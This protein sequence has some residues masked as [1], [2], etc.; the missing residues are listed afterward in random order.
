MI[1]NLL[2]QCVKAYTK[3]RGDL[4]SYAVAEPDGVAIHPQ[5]FVNRLNK[6]AAEDAIFT[7][8][9]GTRLFGLLV[10]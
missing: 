7:F 5:Y 6:L 4:D 3:F 8:D 9:V 1:L 2:T 10:I